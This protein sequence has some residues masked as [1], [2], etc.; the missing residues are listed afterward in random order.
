[1]KTSIL[2]AAISSIS[3]F[4][5]TAN[6]ASTGTITFNG[7][8]TSSTCDVVVDG[9][10]AD[11]TVTLPTVSNTMLAA[12]GDTAGQTGFN[13]SLENCTGTIATAKAFFEAGPTVD[14]STGRLT[15]NGLAT[16]V[17]LQILDGSNGAAPIEVGNASQVA[18]TTG[19]DASS[20]AA[21][22]P[23]MVQYYAEGAT[24][25]GTVESSV[26]YTIHY[27]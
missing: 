6:A 12:A 20:G 16:N 1:M 24:G 15:N 23:Y 25:A 11:A 8:L 14:L 4:S 9:Q 22:L 21:D 3:L 13:I 19:V 17:S 27:Q 5:L 10:T 26:T 18:N 2:I 7:E